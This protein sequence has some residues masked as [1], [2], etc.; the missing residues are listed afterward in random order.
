MEE[1]RTAQ[2]FV[3]LNVFVFI[4]RSSCA[5]K[6]KNCVKTVLGKTYVVHLKSEVRVDWTLFHT[7][8]PVENNWNTFYGALHILSVLHTLISQ[9]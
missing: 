1:F 3:V 7:V 8:F 5:V 2:T 6:V 4:L 9:N